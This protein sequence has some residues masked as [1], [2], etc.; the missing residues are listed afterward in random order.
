VGDQD[1]PGGVEVQQQLA[2]LL[3]VAVSTAPVGSSASSTAGS[4][5][6]AR[7]IATRCRSSPDNRPG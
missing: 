4:L 1:L 6:S 5:T 3:P 7:A 2:D